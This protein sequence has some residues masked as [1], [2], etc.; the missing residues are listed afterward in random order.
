[1]N[2]AHWQPLLRRSQML[3]NLTLVV[4][5]LLSFGAG[6]PLIGLILNEQCCVI[7]R[8]SNDHLRGQCAISA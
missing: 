3:C 1:M 7:R 6:E 2:S 8:C 5:S 4:S